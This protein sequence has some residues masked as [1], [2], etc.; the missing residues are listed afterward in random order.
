[1]LLGGAAALH[2]GGIN[3]HLHGGEP[4]LQRGQHVADGRAARRRH[5]ADAIR[6]ARQLA[7]TCG[8]EQTLGRKAPL[9]LLETPTQLSLARLFDVVDDE[10][11]L[12]ARLIE[13]DAR[14][15]E[16]LLPV[17]HGE[18]QGAVRLPEHRAADLRLRVLQRP[19]LVTGGG[20]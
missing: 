18:L 3:E 20:A 12:A 7:L 4:A 16:H 8:I 10:L 11:K 1:D 5:H 9:E 2:A 17:L 19:I 14:A 15:Y 6:Y 13:T